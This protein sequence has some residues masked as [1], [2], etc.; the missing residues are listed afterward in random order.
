MSE[1]IR[2]RGARKQP[3]PLPEVSPE[4][5]ILAPYLIRFYLATANAKSA[6]L[7]SENYKPHRSNRMARRCAA[8]RH[9]LL[10]EGGG[11]R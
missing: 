7:N 3:A 5:T 4:S 9:R 11:R 2:K 10:F 8:S 6:A 1:K